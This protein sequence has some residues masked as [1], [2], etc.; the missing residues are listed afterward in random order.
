MPSSTSETKPIMMPSEE[1][2]TTTIPSEETNPAI[3]PSE[4]TNPT[5]TT[6][7]EQTTPSPTTMSPMSDEDRYK[8]IVSIWFIILLVITVSSY[9]NL[10]IWDVVVGMGAT[11][12]LAIVLVSIPAARPVFS[13]GVGI[14]L[15]CVAFCM[16]WMAWVY[17]VVG[18]ITDIARVGLEFM[19]IFLWAKVF[20]ESVQFFRDREGGDPNVV[21][22]L[23]RAIRPHN[24]PQ[25]P[26]SGSG[27]DSIPQEVV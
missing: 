6:P 3:T 9:P 26:G 22:R 12:L 5:T 8:A 15:L 27:Y 14:T 20:I 7:S 18:S 1:T 13:D 25:Q 4:E 21:E 10:T 19:G 17:Q 23:G 11:W 24:I 2:N 16:L